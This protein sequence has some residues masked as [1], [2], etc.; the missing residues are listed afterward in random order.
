MK[1]QKGNHRMKKFLIIVFA[2]LAVAAPAGASSMTGYLDEYDLGNSIEAHG[3]TYGGH[4][5]VDTAFCIGLRRYGVVKSGL[6]DEKFHRF[7]CDVNT[8]DNSFWTLKVVAV[9]NTRWQVLSAHK[10]F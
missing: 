10:D 6:F 7:N 8:A 1:R 2:A 3:F 4:H 9:T 5:A